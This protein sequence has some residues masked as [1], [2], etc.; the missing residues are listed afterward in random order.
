MISEP[1]SRTLYLAV[2]LILY[3]TYKK[4]DF[5][6]LLCG[7]SM[8]KYTCKSCKGSCKGGK[9]KA[10]FAASF[11]GITFRLPNALGMRQL[12]HWAPFLMHH[13]PM[14]TI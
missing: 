8:R 11:K 5:T 14:E 6:V 12:L 4:K 3:D 1:L 10:K 9:V 2:R 7:H 13:G